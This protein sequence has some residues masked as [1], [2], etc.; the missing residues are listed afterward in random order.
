MYKIHSGD[1]LDDYARISDRIKV[2][3]KEN[4][5]V[6]SAR[7]AGIEVARGKYINFADS[8]DKLSE[9]FMEECLLFFES[10]YDSLSVCKTPMLFFDAEN[11]AHWANYQFT[12]ENC[13]INPFERPD[14]AFHNV[15]SC[16][17][18]AEDVKS[19][20]F[21]TAL[22]IGE[23][24]YLVNDIIIS[25]QTKLPNS[26]LV[27]LIGKSCY[28]YRKRSSGETSAID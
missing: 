4:G 18:K 10:Q 11:A 22:S 23:D 19:K 3:H 5:G 14:F 13:S 6:S 20:M 9:N 24:M 12:K 17:F 2:I 26:G 21:D 16:V 1:I 25:A 15:S 8:D 28:Y 27:G 7:N